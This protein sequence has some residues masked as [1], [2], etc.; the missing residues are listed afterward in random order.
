MVDIN[1][2]TYNF[3]TFAPRG[4]GAIGNKFIRHRSDCRDPCRQDDDFKS[5]QEVAKCTTETTANSES[6]YSSIIEI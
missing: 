3:S 1:F 6:D 4:G 5:V 2:I